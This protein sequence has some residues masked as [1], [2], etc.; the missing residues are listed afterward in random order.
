VGDPDSGYGSILHTT[1]G[2]T[3]WI[4]QGSPAEIPDTILYDVA[5][6]DAST[7]WVVGGLNGDFPAILRSTDGGATWN[8]QG[9]TDG[10]PKEGLLKIC[11]VD[12]QT[13]WAV[14][15]G[16]LIVH[17]DDGGAT[18]SQQGVGQVPGVHY[19]GVYALD[20]R[21][22]WVT[23]D[24]DSGMGTLV[25]SSDGGATWQRLGTP[26]TVPDT[27]FLDIFMLDNGTGWT[28]GHGPNFLKTTDY[29]R[30]WAIQVG[31]L[32]P[33][34]W[35]FDA[36]AVWAASDHVCWVAEDFGQIVRT[37]D[38]GETWVSNRQDTTCYMMGV[39]ALDANIAW[40]V[41]NYPAPPEGAIARTLD[42]GATWVNQDFPV[43]TGILN[44]AL[45]H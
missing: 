45:L 44:V 41:G 11:A 17:T 20:T 30:T 7:I 13:A 16:G 14:G 29:G 32:D 25:Y 42:A 26:E 2:G 24:V 6:A 23:G 19:Q 4:R 37:G 12:S 8:T 38:G 27:Y 40:A 5:V 28:V 15:T 33:S 3:N 9:T 10:L 34:K 35:F 1:D 22:V 21:R 36:N 43:K 18:W 31:S 39:E